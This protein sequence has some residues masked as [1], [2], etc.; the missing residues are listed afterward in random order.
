M[1]KN[2]P[3]IQF[4]KPGWADSKAAGILLVSAY[5]AAASLPIV[6]AWALRSRTG[7]PFATELGKGAALVGFTL[8]VLQV[9]LSAR[10]R[11]VDRP[12]GYDM[13]MQFHKRM[14]ILAGVLLL[15]HPILLAVGHG[16]LSL[17]SWQTSWRLNLGQAALLLLLVAVLFARFFQKLGIDY[18][19][20][21]ALH[22]GVMVVIVLGFV[23]ALVN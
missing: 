4:A 13:V 20:W 1:S 21:R 19:L 7:A 14:A 8:L 10:F 23:H 3:S 2:T 15:A 18:Q 22:K 9:V 16:S 11:F 17:F 6:L 12:F 5:I